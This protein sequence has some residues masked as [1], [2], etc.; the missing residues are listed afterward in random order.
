M[1]MII[2][3]YFSS[4]KKINLN[5]NRTKVD[6]YMRHCRFREIHP[7]FISTNYFNNSLFYW[8]HT[9]KHFRLKSFINKSFFDFLKFVA[10]NSVLMKCASVHTKRFLSVI[11]KSTTILKRFVSKNNF[12]FFR[13]L[14]LPS[15]FGKISI[16]HKS[17]YLYLS[18]L[19][20]NI[21]K[22]F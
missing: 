7:F 19:E 15:L 18:E 12:I 4:Y 13:D 10:I 2:L 3:S 5:V 11:F 9:H 1:Y 8:F 22:K 21:C 6:F 14:Y 17:N 16:F 20:K